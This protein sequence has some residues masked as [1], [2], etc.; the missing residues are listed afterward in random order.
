MRLPRN[1]P[2]ALLR[3]CLLL[4]CGA[5]LPAVHAQ[6][7]VDGIISSDY[8]SYNAVLASDG[9]YLQDLRADQQTGQ[10]AD[11]FV[12]GTTDNPGFM[13]NLATYDAGTSAGSLDYMVIRV[14]MNT[15]DPNGYNN[16]GK[17]RF[18]I[19]ADADN[20]VDLFFGI[21]GTQSGPPTLGF[22]DPGTD[23]NISPSTSSIG[24]NF[25]PT[26]ESGDA[27][28]S[29]SAAEITALMT[30]T[31]GT[32]YSYHDAATID[33]SMPGF[34]IFATN[35]VNQPDADAYVTFA[36]PVLLLAEA[37]EDYNPSISFDTNSAIRMIAFTATNN[38]T[39]NQ[40]LFGSNGID[41]ATTFDSAGFSAV[42][43]PDGVVP[44]PATYAQLGAMLFVAGGLAW[45]RR[46]QHARD[47]A[48]R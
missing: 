3:C 8:T 6:L 25:T 32:T 20:D 4:G 38:N 48:N 26:F 9:T 23:L 16:N 44:E 5:G 14:R 34:S 7:T 36:I 43:T 31:E 18:G 40:D 13:M 30:L 27:L 2:Y 28:F 15:Y 19:D 10:Y 21:D 45:R 39:I 12:G 35:K 22:Q 24:N 41:G 11:D 1:I 46:R 37:I 42:M 29:L 47:L 17:L 33:G